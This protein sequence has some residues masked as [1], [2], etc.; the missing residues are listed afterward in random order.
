MDAEAVK[1]CLEHLLANHDRAAADTKIDSMEA[2]GQVLTI[3]TSEPKPALLNYLGDPYGCIIDVDAGFDDGIVAG[4]GPYIATDCQ[5]GDHLTLVKNENYWNGTPHIDELTIKTITDGNTL[6]NAL[7]SGE[8]QAAY[9]MAYESYPMF[10]N[11]NFTFSQISTSRCFFLK[12]NFNEGSVCTDP[13]VRKA[14]AMGIDKEGFVENLLEGN[15]YP[16]NGTFPAGSAF[17]GETDRA[18]GWFYAAGSGGI[19]CSLATSPLFATPGRAYAL[20]AV[21]F[22]VFGLLWLLVAPSADVLQA[23]DGLGVQGAEPASS[24]ASAFATVIKM[25][26]VWLVAILLGVAL[27][28]A[29][30]YSGYL[31]SA[32]EV[33]TEPQVAGLLASFVTLGSS[34]GSVAGPYARAQFG[35]YRV[36]MAIAAMA[37]S[38]LMWAGEAFV[39][40]PSVGLMFAIGVSTAVAGP[41]VQ[42]LPYMLPEV[43]EGLAGS[44]G[45]V[46]STVSL[47]LT[48]LIPVALS[49]CIGESYET[50]LF[51]CAVL[52]GATA[53]VSPFLPSPDSLM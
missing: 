4:T 44:A 52:F 12:M 21:L 27:A 49:F 26:M 30:A 32:L 17:G 19:A 38:A 9:G 3:H 8:I 33:S 35:Y 16:A 14:I 1:Q 48:F 28:S 6:A 31:V 42:S 29:T 40:Q 20:A 34:V 10:E 46:V 11:D 7:L 18:M 43:R 51:G 50:L 36:F 5:S 22:A 53:L 45:G 25:P 2:D 13:A 39:S 23:A 47:G 15:G 37:G 41:V 24:S